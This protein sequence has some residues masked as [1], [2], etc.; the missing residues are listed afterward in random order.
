MAGWR[1]KLEWAVRAVDGLGPVWANAGRLALAACASFVG[2]ELI[3]LSLAPLPH[4]ER[5]V[6]IV[7]TGVVLLNLAVAGMWMRRR[8][9]VAM[10]MLSGLMA[11]PLAY[12]YY[13]WVAT[14]GLL[15]SLSHWIGIK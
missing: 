14:C 8:Q 1:E 7:A 4:A 5:L 6:V 12:V 11:A 13:R 15:P 10:G 2:N 3:L 9:A